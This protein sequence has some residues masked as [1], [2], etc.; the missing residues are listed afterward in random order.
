MVDVPSRISEADIILT[1][2]HYRAPGKVMKKWQLNSISHGLSHRNVLGKII[3]KGKK[4]LTFRL[5]GL[6][7][8]YAPEAWEADEPLI[9]NLDLADSVVFQSNYSR[10]CFSEQGIECP[11]YQDIIINGAKSELFF[12][13]SNCKLNPKNVSLI[14]NSWSRNHN[15]GFKTIAQFSRLDN[16]SVIHIGTWPSDIP[17]EKVQLMGI[18]EEKKIGDVLRRGHFLLFPSKNEACPNVVVEALACGLPVLYHDTGGTPE[19]CQ[20]GKLGLALPENIQHPNLFNDFLDKALSLH[21]TMRAR[22]LE[23]MN[24]FS[25]RK[26]YENYI[27]HFHSLI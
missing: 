13:K 21:G 22:I 23:R 3:S 17:S 9:E 12:P 19:L 24:D 14:S 16:V 27:Q 8:I 18:M 1:V 10:N 26:C 25:F 6:R 20:D 7:R 11:E 15:K 5:D 2:G 4:K